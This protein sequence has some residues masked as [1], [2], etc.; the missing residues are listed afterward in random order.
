MTLVE[1]APAV[2][3][4]DLFPLRTGPQTEVLSAAIFREVVEEAPASEVETSSSDS[5]IASMT[6]RIIEGTVAV[7]MEP[8]DSN[9]YPG[10]ANSSS[11]SPEEIASRDKAE[12]TDKE[13]A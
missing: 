11:N 10:T 2:Q 9:K 5:T 1:L 7:D 12:E 8:K 13:A 6:D 4:K 3:D